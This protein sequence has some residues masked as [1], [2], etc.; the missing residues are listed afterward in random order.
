MADLEAELIP[1]QNIAL[2]DLFAQRHAKKVLTLFGQAYGLLP[3]RSSD[4]TEDQQ[5]FLDL[6]I[7]GLTQD[8]KIVP[9]RLALF[10]EMVRERSW[11]TQTLREIGGIEGVGLTFLEE[12]FSS[13]QANPKHRLHQKGAQAVLKALL[14]ETGTDIRGQMRSEPELQD[15]SATADRPREF[16][17]LIHILDNELRLITPTE[18]AS[19]SGGQPTASPGGRYY[20]LTHDYLVHSL[21]DWLTRKQRETRRGR[22]ELRL[23]E[24]SSLWNAKPENRHSPSP[25]EWA[26]IRL[27]TKKK[28][29]TD[30]QS[31][32]MKRAGRVHGVRGLTLATV[33][34]VLSLGGY[35]FYGRLKA[36]MLRD[37]LLGSPL[38]DA[39]SIVAEIKPYQRWV[40]PLL[41]QAYAEAKEAGNSQKQLHAAL[42]LLPVDEMQLPYLKDRLLRADGNDI[43][44]IRQ[45]LAGYKD[46]LVPECWRV[47]DKPVQEAQGKAL[48]AACAL[49]FYDPENTFWEKIRTDVANRL[50]AENAYVVARWIDA[51]RP[52]AKQLSDPLAA[53]FRDEKRG[54]SERTLAASALAE[55]LSDQPRDLAGLLMDATESLFQKGG[56]ERRKGMNPKPYPSDLT[57]QQWAVL[58][59]LLPPARTGGRPRKTEM[60][61]V[62]N[63]IFY[64]NRNGCIWR[65][66]PHDFP[67][68]RTVYNYFAAWKRDGTWKAINDALRRRVR[69]RAGR[70]PTPSAGSIDS[71]IVKTTEGGGEHGYD[72]A[73]RI[74]GRKHHIS[75]DTMGLLLAVAVTSAAVDDAAAAPKV[76]GQLTRKSFPRLRKLWADTKYHYHALNRWVS[77]N[78]WYV[79][80]IVSRLTGDRRFKLLPWR[81]V[82]ERTFG[83][84]GRCRIHSKD[85]EHLTDGT[86]R[87]ELTPSGAF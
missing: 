62:V 81:W 68:W 53:I 48:Q 1:G 44:V 9:V 46:T 85:Y 37:K 34:I 47:L 76:L 70:P 45:A 55:Y 26:N 41:R 84:L 17:E 63:A 8:G 54:E 12:T 50:V 29:W 59:P 56:L 86:E 13:P 52:V 36:Q 65:A 18:P 49:A 74:T 35:E 30:P 71:Q 15:A 7:S 31:K 82:V 58:K 23:A 3:E 20:Q 39:P 75:V 24:R 83:W 78:G 69:R 61:S 64:R 21:R 14:P 27:L 79:I 80:E 25:L 6:A 28:D 67:P 73:K 87:Q 10:A 5:T 66:L 4:L 16:A 60:R 33:L 77:K 57:S 40:D 38:S 11:T 2:V 32:M 43:S 19:S 22:A 51:L 72:G 42:A